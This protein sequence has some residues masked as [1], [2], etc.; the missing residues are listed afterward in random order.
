MTD[1]QDLPADKAS[2]LLLGAEEKKRCILSSM[3][4]VLA[5][6]DFQ[7]HV[8]HPIGAI[9][10]IELT[11]ERV[12]HLIRFSASG[13]YA[14]DQSTS[15][16]SL[17]CCVP[18]EGQTELESQFESLVAHDHVAWALRERRGVM[19]YSQD[20]RYRVLLHVM[21]TYCRIRGLFIG[22]LPVK[23][24]SLPEGS[25]QALSLLLRNAANALESSE[26]LEMF[27]RQNAE[28]QT[29][30]EEKVSQLRQRDHQLLHARKMD[31]IA[32][33]AGGVA[34]Q[35]NNALAV[36]VGSVELIKLQVAQ[37]QSPGSNLQRLES[38]A[39]RM[40]D[41]TS[42]LLAYAR[43][44]KYKVEKVSI[45]VLVQKAMSGAEKALENPV[46]VQSGVPADTYFVHVDLTQMELALSGM[47]TNAIEA[48]DGNGCVVVSAEPVVIE[49]STSEPLTELAEGRYVA[50]RINDNGK[51]MDQNTKEHIFDPFF[52]TKFA[53][54]GLS[55]AA[56]YGIV[57]NHD[58]EI[59]IE[60]EVGE[61]TTVTVYLPLA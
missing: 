56:A 27:Q 44:G 16:L 42:K 17:A 32:T 47:V 22:L 58:G 46:Q 60:S 8:D 4:Q 15:S 7:K 2:E 39:K 34:H 54:R 57:K 19:I 14:V 10:F 29:K 48:L 23:S 36:L 41:L 24:H 31:A 6:G 55:M 35:F 61:G 53:G 11:A 40:Q 52:S 38:V 33:L 18:P 51:G 20:R 25:L 59:Q 49:Q 30:V 5:I 13:I 12:N 43:G 45:E 50:L 9:D 1:M 21:A 37:G 28:L 26:Y 3:E